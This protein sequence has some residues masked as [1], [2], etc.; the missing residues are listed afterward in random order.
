[1]SMG[2]GNA[3]GEVGKIG[4]ELA[5]AGTHAA[6]QG[7]I[8]SA[9]GGNFFQGALAG[10]ISSGVGSGID[11]LGDKLGWS[12]GDIAGA[13]I[14][15]G[16]VSG[17]I[18]SAIGGGNFFDGF[19]QGIAVS[20]FNHGLHNS[21]KII[22]KKGKLLLD[23]DDGSDSAFAIDKFEE[24]V[25]ELSTIN[26]KNSKAV[27]ELAEKYSLSNSELFKGFLGNSENSKMFRAGYYAGYNGEFGAG[28]FAESYGYTYSFGQRIG[29][30][31]RRAGMVNVFNPSTSS[32]MP[33]YTNS[34]YK[35]YN[36]FS[37]YR[38]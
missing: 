9:Q 22:G 23:I 10:G 34:I 33:V 7:G 11:N 31:Y 37:I 27:H 15:G 30:N 12:T 14:L 26:Y 4:K 32:D 3:F 38:Y 36:N 21:T 28:S 2:I 16:G 6:A 35:N 1:M 25:K 19:G 24:F 29:G 5:R 17:G 20:A 13:Q 18:G 8:S